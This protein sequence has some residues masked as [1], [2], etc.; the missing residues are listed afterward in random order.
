MS[1]CDVVHGDCTAVL[2]QWAE[3]GLRFDAVVC[4][5]PYHLTS[6]VKRFGAANAAPAQ[7]GRDG[8]AQRL[9]KG[10][11]GAP[12]DAGDVAFQVE[13]WKAVLSVLK[14]GGRAA[15]FGGT[16]TF[17]KTAAALDAAGFEYEDTI[18][19]CYGQ[20]LVLKQT[21]LKPSWEPVLLVRAPGRV[22]PLNI[23]ECRIPSAGRP[24][25][26]GEYKDTQNNTY[27]GR[28]DSSL[29]GGSKAVGVTDT[30]RWPGNLA[31]DNSAEAVGCFPDTP[32]QLARARTDGQPK[33]HRVY[34]DL[35]HVRATDPEPR[36]DSGSAARFFTSCEFDE[37]E[38]RL[39]YYPK[40]TAA[41]R[42]LHCTI[43]GQPVLH[44]EE[45][46]HQHD[47]KDAA[48]LRGHPTVKPVKLL[49]H[50]IRLLVPPGGLVLDCFAGTG[51]TGVAALRAG[52]NAVL[53]EQ[54]AEY[55]ADIRRRLDAVASL[56]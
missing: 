32:G 8:A 18:A 12:S 39:L 43:C 2:P 3:D 49:E 13:T 47:R 38:K 30:G 10:F 20:G 48:H 37:D 21:R 46:A 41:E 6:I 40:A 35:N 29:R 31:H 51:T 44:G 34:G 56:R 24:A 50:L 16:R 9:S 4:D 53:I 54:N 25:R 36:G 55:C 27:S 15:V 11:M 33:V 14:A 23:E 26:E 42:V 19:W 17:W 22:L 5:P 45:A 52:R 1:S 7:F 28:L